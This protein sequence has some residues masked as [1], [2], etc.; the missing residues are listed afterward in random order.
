MGEIWRTIFET[1]IN[2][3][4]ALLYTWFLF[5]LFPYRSI[6][7]P[8]KLAKLLCSAAFFLMMTL[9]Q[10]QRLWQ[11]WGVWLYFLLSLGCTQLFL[12]GSMT[13]KVLISLLPSN[14]AMIGSLLGQNFCQ[15]LRLVLTQY[16]TRVSAFW[17]TF[18]IWEMLE[19]VTSALLQ[20]LLLLLIRYLMVKIVL[21]LSR[22]ET[23]LAGTALSISI[24]I[25]MALQLYAMT[26]FH[27]ISSSYTSLFFQ[28]CCLSVII[29][30]ILAINVAICVLLGK[31]SEQH[32]LETENTLLRYQTRVQEESARELKAHYQKLQMIRHDF[33]NS[34]F[35]LETLNRQGKREELSQY[36]SQYLQSQGQTKQWVNTDNQIFNAV[37]NDKLSQAR[38]DGVEV[39]VQVPPQVTGVADVDLCNLISNLLDNAM[40]A[41]RRCPRKKRIVFLLEAAPREF[42]L[43]VKNTIPASVLQKNPNL[44][45]SKA[46]AES[47]GY[48]TRIIQ[49]LVKKYHGML[50]YYEEDGYF[51][52]HLILKPEALKP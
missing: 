35:V 15:L 37:L 8:Q 25:L 44:N 19:I 49:N 30:G 43:W 33:K 32:A 12:E 45:S 52:C 13:K 38:Q 50:E 5:Q 40:E 42:R 11:G 39:S 48:G 28:Q 26:R 23:M 47:H 51:C 17:N 6:A 9:F 20:I 22:W 24:F 2:G 14:C 36:I 4:E 21:V 41:A 1:V 18:Q 34:L 16:A 3:C 7:F 31:L 29:L 46:D 10:P 27:I